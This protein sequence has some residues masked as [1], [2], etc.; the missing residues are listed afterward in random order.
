[1]L[2]CG[3][4]L[5]HRNNHRVGGERQGKRKKKKKKKKKGL[6]LSVWQLINE[7]YRIFSVERTKNFLKE[8]RKE[9][10]GE[11]EKER[12]REKEREGEKR[13]KNQRERKR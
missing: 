8:V 5:T 2:W 9:G 11:K 1:M 4:C 13:R 3:E 6:Q 7:K 10:K 12:E